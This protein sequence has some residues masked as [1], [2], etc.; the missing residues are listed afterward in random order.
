M[1][2]PGPSDT[3]WVLGTAFL[4]ILVLTGTIFP[5]YA[6]IFTEAKTTWLDRLT[7]RF[8]VGLLMLAFFIVGG[9]A[10]GLG[11]MVMKKVWGSA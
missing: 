4:L 7:R 8:G 2:H 9:L 11:L 6:A 3:L 1:T 5:L 10:I